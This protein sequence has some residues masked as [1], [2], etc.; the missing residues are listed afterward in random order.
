MN[1]AFPMEQSLDDP[2]A[3]VRSDSVF[4]PLRTVLLILGAALCMYLTVISAH[5]DAGKLCGLFG[6]DCLGAVHSEY[7]RLFGNSVSSIGLGYFTFQLVLTVFMVLVGP[8]GPVLLRIQTMAAALALVVSLYFAYVLRF[9][10]QQ[11]CIACYVVHVV[12]AVVFALCL[13][14]LC[15]VLAAERLAHRSPWVYPGLV[16]ALAV[17]VLFASNATLAASL[18]ET[19]TV[20]QTEQKKTRN[21]L[22]YSRFLHQSSPMN[23]FEVLPGDTIVGEPEKA[24]HQIVLLYKEG[25]LYCRNAKERLVDIVRKNE[26]AVY[27]LM[28]ETGRIPPTT[29]EAM[30]LRQVP[31]VFIDGRYAEGWQVPGFLEFFTRDCGC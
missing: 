12:N 1:F 13:K 30:R 31:A 28:R 5:S 21:N 7:G 8:F 16:S 25:C 4:S 23:I 11:A 29:L 27:L 14:G 17:S 22:E 18:M 20:L 24:K 9:I 6:G 26:A 10:L 15:G 19:R 3:P 2:S